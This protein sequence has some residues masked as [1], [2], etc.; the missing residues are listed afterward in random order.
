MLMS[1]AVAAQSGPVADNRI[2][3]FV[4]SAEE[5]YKLNVVPG[6]QTTIEFQEKE[7]IRTISLGDGTGFKVT[8]ATNRLFLKASRPDQF[9]NMYVLTNERAYYFDLSSYKVPLEDV[10]YVVRFYYPGQGSRRMAVHPTRMAQQHTAQAPTAP[11]QFT[12]AVAPGVPS[13]VQNYLT[14]PVQKPAMRMTLNANYRTTGN[15]LFTPTKI[16][17]DGTATYMQ[18]NQA[19]VGSMFFALTPDGRELPLQVQ[20]QGQNIKI[21]QI[22]GK[23]VMRSGP[24][25]TCIYNDNNRV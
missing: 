13:K 21:P 14:G 25:V 17:D 2:Q 4:Y 19:A 11:P 5:V 8:P 18:L 9:T 16:F 12:Q 6:Y 10:M 24:E 23:I 1:V 7:K 22:L 20:R 3:T 15:P